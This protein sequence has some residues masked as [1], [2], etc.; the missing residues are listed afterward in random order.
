MTRETFYRL[1][2]DYRSFLRDATTVLNPWTG[3]ELVAKTEQA[4]R[5]EIIPQTRMLQQMI[6]VRGMIRWRKSRKIRTAT[7]IGQ[8]IRVQ[9]PLKYWDR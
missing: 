1:R 6:S 8:M 5:L 9:P 4:T 3:N 2:R 7:Q